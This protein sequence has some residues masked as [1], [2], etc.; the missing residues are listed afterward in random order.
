MLNEQHYGLVGWPDRIVA[1]TCVDRIRRTNELISIV[2]HA[3]E[4]VNTTRTHVVSQFY[5]DVIID[6][7]SI[8]EDRMKGVPTQKQGNIARPVR[9]RGGL[10][11]D[12]SG[13]GADLP[14]YTPPKKKR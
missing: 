4:V 9:D 12:R 7:I 13:D 1:H 14:K 11:P 2:S 6:L 3:H 8:E 5:T 10:R